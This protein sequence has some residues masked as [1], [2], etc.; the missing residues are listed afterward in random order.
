MTRA[1]D[2]DIAATADAFR[3]L[4]RMPAREV[5]G[6]AESLGVDL[7]EAKEEGRSYAESLQPLGLSP[8][9][10]AAMGPEDAA[11][12]RRIVDCTAFVFLLG[13]LAAGWAL[14][15]REG[16]GR[17]DAFG[18]TNLDMG[19]ILAEHGQPLAMRALGYIVEGREPF[20]AVLSDLSV[21]AWLAPGLTDDDER[22]RWELEA[23]E[24]GMHGALQ[25]A[26]AFVPAGGT[27]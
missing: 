15:Q 6:I 10:L 1:F 22:E 14:Q 23:A 8:D 16:Q 11:A 24:A 20:R 19:A 17:L 3:R 27:T 4:T 21:R 12:A 13:A 9:I 26:F 5:V 18:R 7:E 25:G 2:L